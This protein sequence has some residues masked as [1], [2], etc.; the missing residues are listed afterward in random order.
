[1]TKT[2]KMLVWA[3]G[4]RYA[5]SMHNMMVQFIEDMT[6]DEQVMYMNDRDALKRLV[7]ARKPV[8]YRVDRAGF[9]AASPLDIKYYG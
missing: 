1:M 4:P 6:L 9:T 2:T 8:L 5:D 7:M 3:E